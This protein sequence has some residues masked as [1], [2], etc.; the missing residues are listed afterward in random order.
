M[1]G[2]AAGEHNRRD[3]EDGYEDDSFDNLEENDEIPW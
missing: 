1:L 3:P 2:R